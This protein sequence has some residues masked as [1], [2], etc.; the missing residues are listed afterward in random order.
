MGRKGTSWGREWEGKRINLYI[1]EGK[2]PAGE[3]N[4]EESELVLHKGRKGTSWEGESREGK[5]I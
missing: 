2:G 3:G 5:L 1:W 4:G